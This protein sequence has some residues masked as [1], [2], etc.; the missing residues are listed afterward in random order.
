MIVFESL[1]SIERISIIK[2]F[3]RRRWGI[4][5]KI[6]ID[7]RLSKLVPFSAPNAQFIYLDVSKGMQLLKH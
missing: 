3:F 4:V 5:S 6:C 2:V 1:H 7:V